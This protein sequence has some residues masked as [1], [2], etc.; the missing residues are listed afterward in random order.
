M[1]VNT[2]LLTEK[3]KQ[4]VGEISGK[5]IQMILEGRSLYYMAEQLKL[6]PWEVVQ[7]MD[8][9]LYTLKKQVGWKRYLR[10]FFRK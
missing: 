9:M 1:F 3:Q 6:E 10:N 7:N 8:E 5:T 4:Q 2:Y